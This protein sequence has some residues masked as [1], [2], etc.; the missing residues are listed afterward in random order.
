FFVTL[1][2][3]DRE[4]TTSRQKKETSF[5]VFQA[6]F[7]NSAVIRPRSYYVSAKK[8]TSFFVL[9]STF[10]NFAIG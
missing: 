1:R 8:E 10:R 7:R 3:F 9:R 2:S 6:L 5:F 4:V